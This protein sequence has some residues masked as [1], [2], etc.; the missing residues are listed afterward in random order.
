MRRLGTKASLLAGITALASPFALVAADE[1]PAAPAAAGESAPA[2]TDGQATAAAGEDNPAAA[3]GIQEIVITAQ[4][5]AESLQEVPISVTALTSDELAASNI[6]GQVDLPKITPNLN[7]TVNS[8][9]ASPYIRGV[10]TQ[11]G[12]PG[13]EPSVSVYM[14]DVYI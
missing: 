14:D 2:S 6:Q 13:L 3:G 4:K 10:G 12:N 5:R 9:F 11:F 1:A 7:F 8:G